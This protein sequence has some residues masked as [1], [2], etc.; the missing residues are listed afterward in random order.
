M[1]RVLE[2]GLEA[3]ARRRRSGSA[4]SRSTRSRR[5]G[6]SSPIS[7][8]ATPRRPRSRP[9]RCALYRKAAEHPPAEAERSRAPRPTSWSRP[10]SS[11]RAIASSSSRSATRT[12]PPAAASRPP[13]RS[14]R[15]WSRTA[16]AARRSWPPS[17]TGSPRRTWP[18]ARRRGRSSELD[19][20]F[21]ID[22]GSIA[23]LR[24]L[25]VLS[26][27]LSRDRR[28]RGQ[29]GAH[30]PRAEDLPR[31]APPEARRQLAHLQGRG[32]LLPRPTSATG[33]ATTRRPSRCWSARS[34]PT[35]STAPRRSCSAKLKK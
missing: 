8:R 15:S 3:D 14:R 11:R 16:A 21:K 19:I 2:R 6:P 27:E 31:A 32:L 24:D 10:P 9:R 22:P 35:R 1:R 29:G 7:S 26:L 28:R 23:V 34:T 12:A 13:R 33:R 4:S 5:P 17:T 30:R 20:A 18:R 25:G